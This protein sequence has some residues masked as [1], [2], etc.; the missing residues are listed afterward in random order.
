MSKI[1][2]LFKQLS[3]TFFKKKNNKFPYSSFKQA[4][5]INPT[6]NLDQTCPVLLKRVNVASDV[7]DG[8]QQCLGQ[9]HVAVIGPGRRQFYL[10]V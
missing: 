9:H 5:V 4:T 10:L 7:M 3:Q 6:I 1:I 8:W 2:T